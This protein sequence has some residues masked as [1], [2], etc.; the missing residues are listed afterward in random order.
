M[1]HFSENMNLNKI[2]ILKDVRPKEQF[3]ALTFLDYV[4]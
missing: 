2:P 3:N 4:S 1:F